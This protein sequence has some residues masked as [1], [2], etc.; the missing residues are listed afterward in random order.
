MA[1]AA[2]ILVCLALFCLGKGGVPVYVLM[3]ALLLIHSFFT[4][5]ASVVSSSEMFSLAAAD[6]KTVDMAFFGACL[7]GGQGLSRL[8]PS[9]LMGSNTA[10]LRFH[11]GSVSVCRYQVIFLL[12][13]VGVALAALAL[14]KKQEARIALPSAP[15]DVCA[16]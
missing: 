5:A 3:A 15:E 8:I 9:L 7:Y 11:L 16:V 1:H 13:A 6:N 2:F 4:A 10:A 12:A 14:P